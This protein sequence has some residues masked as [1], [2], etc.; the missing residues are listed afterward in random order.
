MDAVTLIKKDHQTV[1]ALFRRYEKLGPRAYRQA[2]HIRDRV[3]QELTTHAAVEEQVLYPE[4]RRVRGKAEDMVEQAEDEHGQAK[5]AIAKL[6][7]LSPKSVKFPG[8]MG[9]LMGGVR[10]HVKEEESELL[11]K[12][13]KAMSKAELEKLGKRLA[14]AKREAQRNQ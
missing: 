14:S 1:E 11:P 2:G 8:A 5:K 7:R 12:L 4:A 3:C 10:H 6:Q 9:R 13:E